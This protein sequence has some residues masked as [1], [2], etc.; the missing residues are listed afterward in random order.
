MGG[1]KVSSIELTTKDGAAVKL[2]IAEAQALYAQLGELFGSKETTRTIP[3]PAPYPVPV[4]PMPRPI[5]IPER[6]PEPWRPRWEVTCGGSS[7]HLTRTDGSGL[8][9][10]YRGDLTS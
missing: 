2:T 1:L 3:I 8:S 6:W 5:L 4:Y 10:S 7:K 9:V